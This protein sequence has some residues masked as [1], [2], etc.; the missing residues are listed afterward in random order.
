MLVVGRIRVPLESDVE[1]VELRWRAPLGS[2][3][4]A[5]F[6]IDAPGVSAD[7]VSAGDGVAM[8]AGSESRTSFTARLDAGTPAAP[9]RPIS[10]HVNPASIHL[11]DPATGAALRQ[12]AP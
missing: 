9:G 6:P 4:L 10:L 1:T 7:T 8:M 12:D 2:E 11:F 3:I 5:V